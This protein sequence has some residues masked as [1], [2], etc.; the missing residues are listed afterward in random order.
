MAGAVRKIITETGAYDCLDCG[1]CTAACSIARHN[2]GFSPRMLVYDA[3]QKREAILDDGRLWDCL[4]CSACEVICTSGVR[5]RKFIQRL[6]QEASTKG[7]CGQCTHGGAIQSL[8]HIMESH[9]LKQERLN[10]VP[11]KA[12]TSRVSDTVYFVGCAPYFDVF[13]QDI[14]VDTLSAAKGSIKLLNRMGIIPALMPDERCCGHDL[15]N[16]G[17]VDGFLR[18]ARR[19]VREISATGAHRVV[20]SCP[21]GYHMF[22]AEYPSY[23]GDVGIEVVHL[24]Q[25]LAEAISSGELSFKKVNKK[26]AYHDSCRLG[27][28]SGIYEEPR[29]ILEAIPGLE[30]KEMA[31]HRSNA[32]CCGTQSWM[33]CGTINKQMQLELAREAEATGADI[34]LTSCPKCQIH[35]KCALNDQGQDGESKI[36]IQDFTGFVAG[37]LAK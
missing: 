19:N 30:V 26:V 16:A 13:F 12:E 34:L 23:L 14:D 7:I 35:L 29:A 9:D 25:L 32:L 15:L 4:T 33:N 37:A 2:P 10:W 20:F 21:E 8:M 27:R 6:R 22:R 17:D 36:N 11:G 1:K 28:I 5:Y 31:H 18:L 24:T 3:I